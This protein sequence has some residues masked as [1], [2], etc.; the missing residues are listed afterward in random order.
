MPNDV[1]RLINQ[2]NVIKNG[3]SVIGTGKSTYT[4]RSPQYLPS[5]GISGVENHGNLIGRWEHLD[6]SFVIV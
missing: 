4:A 3:D 2:N 1:V 5:V 6:P